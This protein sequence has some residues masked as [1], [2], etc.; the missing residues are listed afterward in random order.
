MA[1]R[2]SPWQHVTWKAY[3]TKCHE[4]RRASVTEYISSHFLENFLGTNT[5]GWFSVKKGV[6]AE[7]HLIR[8]VQYG[9]IGGGGGGASCFGVVFLPKALGTFLE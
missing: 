4:N 2:A 8:T 1:A 6:H 5:P 7:K 9:G 3:Q